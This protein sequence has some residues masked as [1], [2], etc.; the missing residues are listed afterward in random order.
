VTG[1]LY[2][3][4]GRFGLLAL[5]PFLDRTPLR[6]LRRRPIAAILGGLLLIVIVV[7]SIL[8]ATA[9]VAQHLG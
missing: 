4:V 3:G 5:L 2:A 1:I 6:R 7:L 9:P 8:V